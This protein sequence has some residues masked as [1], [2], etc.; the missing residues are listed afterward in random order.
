MKV[1]TLLLTA[2][3]VSLTCGTALARQH[4]GHQR[5]KNHHHEYVN[6]QQNDWQ[7]RSNWERRQDR[8]HYR[9]QIN[10]LERKRDRIARKL[11]AERREFRQ[12]RQ[13]RHWKNRQQRRFA[14]QRRDDYRCNNQPV[15]TRIRIPLPPI[16]RVALFFPW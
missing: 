10:R 7:Y 4:H 9:R 3:I 16:P 14:N 13:W 11:R 8:K 15:V 1:S 12:W 5:N 6:N 2:A